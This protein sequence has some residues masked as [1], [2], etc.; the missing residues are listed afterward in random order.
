VAVGDMQ[1]RAIHTPGHTPGSTC[2]V[3]P[4]FLFSGDALFPGGPGKTESTADFHQAMTSL[5]RLFG[6]L[7]D[8]MRICPGHGVDSTIGRERAHVEVWRARGW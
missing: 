6:E 8:E 5:D 3:V 1:V 7:G 4:G 2:F